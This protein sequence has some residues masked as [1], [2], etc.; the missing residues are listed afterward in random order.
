MIQFTTHLYTLSYQLD[1]NLGRLRLVHSSQNF[2][3]F[4]MIKFALN[5]WLCFFFGFF[6]RCSIQSFLALFNFSAPVGHKTSGLGY[7]AA[8]NTERND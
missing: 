2:W 3:L 4:F 7:L 1:C 8:F 5:V 6:G